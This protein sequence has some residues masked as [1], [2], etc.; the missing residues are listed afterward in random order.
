MERMNDE[1]TTDGRDAA[2]GGED[3]A[4]RGGWQRDVVVYLC[5]YYKYARYRK[6]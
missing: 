5:V 1:K 4:R 6:R 2:A 3:G